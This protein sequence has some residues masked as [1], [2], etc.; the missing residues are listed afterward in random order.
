VQSYQRYQSQGERPPGSPSYQAPLPHTNGEVHHPPQEFTT[1]KKHKS[2]LLKR[3][4]EFLREL[5]E[6]IILGLMCLP[7]LAAVL[8]FFA[9][10]GAN[11]AWEAWHEHK[12]WAPIRRRT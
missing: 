9:I 5:S 12:R 4:G 6:T 3:I 2:D 1:R 8:A 10:T 11:A 7:V